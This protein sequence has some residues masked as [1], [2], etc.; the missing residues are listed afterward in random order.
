MVIL[1]ACLESMAPG[2]TLP[3]P[4]GFAGEPAV[5]GS[6]AA[7]C[8]ELP[9][10]VALFDVPGIHVVWVGEQ[11]GTDEMP[12]FLADLACVAGTQG[13]PV[14]VALER[15]PEEQSDWDRFLDSDG[16]PGAVQIL[17][18]APVWAAVRDGRNSRAILAMAERL[19][20]LKQEGRIRGVRLIDRWPG[21]SSGL[22]ISHRDEEMAQAVLDVVRTQPHA[23]VLVYSGNVHAMKRR[24]AWLPADVPDPAASYLPPAEILSINLIGEAGEF[25]SCQA[26]GC[27]R[28]PYPGESGHIRSV[29]LVGGLSGDHHSVASEGFDALAYTGLA[30]TASPPAILRRRPPLR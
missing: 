10:A 19:R 15:A 28:H 23:L 6:S 1:V 22:D 26:S 18:E 13:R 21:T 12:A 9:G 7:P 30:T 8:R 2:K 17:T 16:S 4:S 3:A 27:G 14:I 29:V 5:H 24:T 11:H 20:S 25:W